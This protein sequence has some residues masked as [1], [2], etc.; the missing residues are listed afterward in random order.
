MNRILRRPMFRMGG[1]SGTGITSGLDKPRKQYANGTPN[2]SNSID[3][4][5]LLSKFG[6][7]SHEELNVVPQNIFFS[8][9]FNKLCEI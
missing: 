3:N 2:P 6:F 4:L 5:I 7:C 9:F 1:S 8:N